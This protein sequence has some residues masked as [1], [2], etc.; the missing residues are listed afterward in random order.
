M[1]ETEKIYILVVNYIQHFYSL[2]L[3]ESQVQP[4]KQKIDLAKSQSVCVL[5][6]LLIKQRSFI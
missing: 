3:F 5:Y 1:R 4:N 2:H 6:P